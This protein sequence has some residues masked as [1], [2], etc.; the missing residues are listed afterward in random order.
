MN[1][2]KAGITSETGYIVKSLEYVDDKVKGGLISGKKKSVKMSSTSYCW[3]WE[4]VRTL[5]GLHLKTQVF[6]LK[7]GI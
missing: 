3:L 4:G 5:K 7:T 1:S 2:K 6:S